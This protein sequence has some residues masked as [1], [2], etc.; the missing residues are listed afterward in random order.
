L[1]PER[2]LGGRAVARAQ[3][4]ENDAVSGGAPAHVPVTSAGRKVTWQ[5][6]IA[7]YSRRLE[8]GKRYD[9]TS[10][11]RASA[12]GPIGLSTQKDSPDWRTYGFMAVETV[13]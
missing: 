13:F 6:E 4:D 12:P 10:S 11:A 9:L 2:E 1:A 7:P 3:R 5:I 8:K